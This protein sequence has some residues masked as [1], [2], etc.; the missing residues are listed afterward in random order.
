MLKSGPNRT[1]NKTRSVKPYMVICYFTKSHR[2]SIKIL[3]NVTEIGVLQNKC[4]KTL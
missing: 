1:E 4:I 2:E 3:N